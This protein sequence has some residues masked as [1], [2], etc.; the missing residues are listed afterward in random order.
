MAARHFTAIDDVS[1]EE[2]NALLQLSAQMK[3]E[4][5]NFSNALAGKNLAMIF[6]KPSTRT[7]VSFEVAIN[8]LGGH[9]LMLGAGDL[10]LGRGE[11]LSDTAQVLSRY[12]D[13]IMARVFSHNDIIE[14]AKYATVPV[15]NGLSDLLHPCQAVCD[16]LTIQER[17]GTTR[18]IKVVYLG[19]GNNV[20]HSLALAAAQLGAHL[21]LC[22]P[23]GRYAP[24]A[25]IVDRAREYAAKNNARITLSNDPHAAVEDA[26]VLYTDVWTS[27]GQEAENERRL[28]DLAE[29]RVDR[30][31]FESA[32]D[33]AI[34]M[35]CLPAHRGEEVTADVADHQRSVIFDQAENRLH[36][37]KAILYTLLR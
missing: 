24:Q 32:A 1:A 31:L 29:F 26:Q 16:F 25:A 14:L 5:Q 15:I 10:Q 17:F 11:T 2:L 13:V 19:D 30:M 6:Q 33:D 3:A 27:M 28:H 37:E 34:F 18:G 23:G 21:T 8:Q 12:V 22:T 36:T 9:A 4:P 20:A 35:H 7:R